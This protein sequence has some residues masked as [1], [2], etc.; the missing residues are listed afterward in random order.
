M[1]LTISKITKYC[2]KYFYLFLFLCINTFLIFTLIT[3]KII[4]GGTCY[5]ITVRVIKFYFRYW[6][7]EPAFWIQL[8]MAYYFPHRCLDELQ[9][10]DLDWGSSFFALWTHAVNRVERSIYF[11]TIYIRSRLKQK[12]THLR[13]LHLWFY[14]GV[15]HTMY[16]ESWPRKMD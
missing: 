6:E 5:G 8:C 1:T 13:L 11:H 3:F 9:Y 15:F 2:K 7:N 16:H 12:N 14:L 4:L 10:Q